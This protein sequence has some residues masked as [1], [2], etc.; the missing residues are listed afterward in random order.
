MKTPFATLAVLFLLIVACA[1]TQERASLTL[2]VNSWIGYGPF[3]LA[4]EKGFFTDEGLD[5]SI[6]TT[7]GTAERKAAMVAN[8]IDVLG[9]TVDLLVLS[10]DEQVPSVAVMELD[11][12]NGADGIIVT[13]DIK[14]VADL[15]GKSIAVQKNFVGESFLLY[16]LKKYDLSPDDVEL[17]DMESGAAGAAFVAGSVDVAVTYEPWLSKA[18]ERE[19]GKILISSADEPGVIVDILSVHEDVLAQRPDDIKKLMRAWFRAVDYAKQNPEEANAIMAK[20]YDL[21]PQEFA[22][23]LT[24]VE[25]PGYEENKAYF[26]NA[27]AP[28]RILDVADVFSSA[29]LEIGIIKERPDMQQAVDGS[30]LATLYG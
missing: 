10:R 5:V 28:G 11:V 2:S 3:Y 22:D 12:S 25:W 26:G 29:F 8:R 17:I 21:P 14:T 18:K 7:E 13:D 24:G 23:I 19:N 27:E 1:G 20:Y 16:V 4:Q 9:D 15:K 30:L 6:V